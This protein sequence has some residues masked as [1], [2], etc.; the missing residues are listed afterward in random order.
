LLLAV[1]LAGLSVAWFLW[2]HVGARPELVERQL[3]AN[4]FEDYVSGAAISPDGKYVAYV[5]QTGL[6]LRSIDSGE[7]RA[8]SVSPELRSRIWRIWWFPE[9]GKLLATGTSS[10]GVDLWV[11][12]ILGEG[13]PR[14]LYRH[15]EYPAISPD[16]RL[17]AFVNGELGRRDREVSVG[18]VSGETAR[19]LVTEGDNQWVFSP[20]WS[21]DGRW[22]AYGRR[23]KVTP[24]SW[25]S[26][27]ELRPAGGGPAKTL[28]PESSLPQSS[29]FGCEG[30]SCFT[31]LPDWRLVFAVSQASGSP[32]T[33]A[34]HGLWVVR[35]E[36][37]E[38][39]AAGKPEQLTQG[40][41]E[42]ASNLGTTSLGDLTISADGKRLSFLRTYS[43]QDV[44]VGELGPHGASIKPARRFTLDNRGSCP[45]DWTRDSQ[46]ILFSSNRTGKSE[47]FRQALK[48]TVPEAIV[49]GPGDYNAA[50]SPGGSW[51]L[52]GESP[53]A[54]PGAPPAPSRLMR[55]PVG[56][57]SPE[58][59][60]EEP[61]GA[62]WDFA[63][64]AKPG[65]SC[66]LRQK[67][68]KDYVFYSLDPVR[69]RGEQ[70]GR[71]EVS[72]GTGWNI[73][74]DGSR[75]ALVDPHKYHGRIEVLTVRGHSWR[76]LSTD[77]GWGDFQS[78]AWSADGKGFFVTSWLPNSFNL[79]HVTLGGKVNPLLRN[80]HR[81]FMSN[82]LP[83]PDGKWLAFQGETTDSN[84]W[85]LEGF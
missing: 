1:T 31:W 40:K 73:S 66:V 34:K 50:I 48:E 35:V 15:G 38:G 71:V 74:P 26:A 20:A 78:I 12:T 47:V 75:L 44:Y 21:P 72:Y 3:T 83:S 5:D 49:E 42:A 64:P 68:E 7:T 80:G 59:V 9:N 4:P 13:P 19:K 33:Q 36:P 32:T 10:E 69:G 28:L 8:V 43:W 22:I 16:G 56:G 45:N 11:I 52:Y 77:P 37:Q 61:G 57:G 62:Q 30:P 67:E 55:R 27:I 63:C 60:L 53:T 14:L 24:D 29:S 6:Y 79:L 84:V 23:R 76:E 25:S 46:A 51:L 41:G 65:S 70:L 81:Q 54:T 85:L 2:H 17:I 39:K 82:P 58:M 18:S